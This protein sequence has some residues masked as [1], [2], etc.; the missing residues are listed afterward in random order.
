MPSTGTPEP[1]GARWGPT[2]SF[3]ERLF[4]VSRVVACDVVELA[5]VPGMHHADFTV[6]RLIYKMIGFAF[7][8]HLK[9]V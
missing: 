3:L 7:R 4:R 5:P 8:D 6:A 9:N 1:G 2:L